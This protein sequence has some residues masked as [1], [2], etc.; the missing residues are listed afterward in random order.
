MSVQIAGVLLDPYGEIASF[1]EIKFITTQGAGE[2]MTTAPATYKTSADG[3]YSMNIQFGVFIVQM[4]YNQSNGKFQQI[5]KVIVNSNTVATTLGELLLNNEP[6]TPPEIAYVEQLVAEAK[7]Y[8]D[9]SEV[10]AAASEASAQNSASSAAE[11]AQSAIDAA[12]SAALI[13][14]IPLNGGVWASGQ[15]YDFYNQYMIYNGEAYS[16]L[17]ATVLPYTVGAVPDLGFVYQIKLNDHSLLANLNAVGAHDK[18]YRRGHDSVLDCVNYTGHVMGNKYEV[19]DYYG[20]TEPSNSGVLFFTVVP[21]GTGTADGGKYIDIDANFQL[22]QNLKIPYNVKQWGAK[23]DDTT[24]ADIPFSNAI[25]Y[26]RANGLVGQINFSGK[27]FFS[28]TPVFYSH[29]IYQGAGKGGTIL[30]VEPGKNGV[31]INP[32]PADSVSYMEMRDFSIKSTNTFP[33]V[34]DNVGLK[35]DLTASCRRLN[36]RDVDI[37]GF[38]NG[39]DGKCPFYLCTFK[40]M[41]IVGIVPRDINDI[42]NYTNDNSFGFASGFNDNVGDVRDATTVTME[43]VFTGSFGIGI[44]NRYTAAMQLINCVSERNFYGVLA[45]KGLYGAMYQEWNKNSCLNRGLHQPTGVQITA[46]NETSSWGAFTAAT[47][48]AARGS[49]QRSLNGARSDKTYSD[50]LPIVVSTSTQ[51]FEFQSENGE[52]ISKT[53]APA[54]RIIGPYEVEV[55]LTDTNS[56]PTVDGTYII[57]IWVKE[58]AEAT[59]RSVRRS[60]MQLVAANSFL[61]TSNFNYKGV[62]RGNLSNVRVSVSR[63]GGEG[64]TITGNE[65]SMVVRR[66]SQ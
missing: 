45:D 4:R 59:Y 23:A 32:T 50:V 25:A 34:N 43:N 18:I 55:Y 37:S 39:V 33:A 12:N 20:G 64:F 61:G 48:E 58:D 15:T 51:Y 47:V 40:N 53:S 56:T 60:F 31:Q 24:P 29:L 6:L 7:E 41:Q 35:I 66:I 11:S 65:L 62:V 54:H 57:D 22:E 21:A 49:Y 5:K 52:A 13:A 8:R 44:H 38:K 16:P 1:A 46:I 36:I 19:D 14:P 26:A 9:E 10:F 63:V 42:P 28:E 3:S 27:F 17:P 2:V 30:R